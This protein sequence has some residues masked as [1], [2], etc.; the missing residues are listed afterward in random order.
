MGKRK[1]YWFNPKS[2]TNW[3]KT[4]SPATRRRKLLASTDKRKSLHDRR[5]AAGR[6][7]QSLANVS[8]DKRT[9]ELA[10]KDAVYFFAKARKKK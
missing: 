4:Q 1:K 7:I 10:K 6:K 3:K 8:R 2:H 9:A 5:V